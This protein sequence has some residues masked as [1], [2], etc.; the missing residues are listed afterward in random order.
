MAVDSRTHN[1]AKC[2][3][4]ICGDLRSEEGDRK[5]SLFSVQWLH[6]STLG[7]RADVFRLIIMS[8]SERIR[9]YM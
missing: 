4:G 5:F 9:V 3:G 2:D 6:L 8:N 7:G 1:W